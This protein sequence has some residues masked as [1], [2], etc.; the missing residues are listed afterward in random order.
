VRRGSTA[1]IAQ[2]HLDLIADHRQAGGLLL[3]LLQPAAQRA[4]HVAFADADPEHRTRGADDH[5]RRH[6]ALNRS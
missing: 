6:R 2:H 5:A 1:S 3:H 4:D